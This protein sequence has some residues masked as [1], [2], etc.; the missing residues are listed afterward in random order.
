MAAE[1]AIL[2]T[3]AV[4]P[5]AHQQIIAGVSTK[6]RGVV[7]DPYERTLVGTGTRR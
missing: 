1:A 5:L 2:G 3:D 4:V 6:V 7:L